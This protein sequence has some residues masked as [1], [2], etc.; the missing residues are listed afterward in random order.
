MSRLDALLC[1][2]A[3]WAGGTYRSEP[4]FTDTVIYPQW[5]VDEMVADGFDMSGFKER[6]KNCRLI[7][8]NYWS[9]L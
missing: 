5:M 6:I 9:K 4:R 8:Y 3:V 2:G 7:L 1:I